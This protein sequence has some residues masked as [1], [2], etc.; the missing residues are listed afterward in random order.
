MTLVYGLIS[1]I[2]FGILLQKA[3]VLRYDKQVGAMRFLDMTIFKFML[4]AI[5]VAGV[6]IYLLKDLGLIHLSIKGTSIGAQLIGGSL[7]GVGWGLLGYC[8]GTAVGAIGEGRLD[9]VWGIFG[10]LAGAAL[11]AES[12]SFMK[13]KVIDLGN[14]GKITLPQILGLNHWFVIAGFTVIVL[15][16]FA[17][18]EKKNL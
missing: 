6:G 4:S 12:Y 8:P 13:A 1:G 5:I 18:F 16:A 10:M 11:Y 9:A 2:L 17:F 15:A 3:Q 14:Y 7:F